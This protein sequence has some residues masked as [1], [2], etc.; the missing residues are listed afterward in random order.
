VVTKESRK[1]RAVDETPGFHQ[2]KEKRN[3]MPS[4]PAN[5]R[6]SESRTS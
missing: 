3:D 2:K 5:P 6:P 1:D 4:L